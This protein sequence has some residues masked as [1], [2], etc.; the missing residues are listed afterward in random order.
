[1]YCNSHKE[2]LVYLV[3][4]TSLRSN[5]NTHPQC[6]L[7]LALLQLLYTIFCLLW[8]NIRAEKCELCKAKFASFLCVNKDSLLVFASLVTSSSMG[9]FN[10]LGLL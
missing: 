6:R 1:M 2:K 9:L 3:S 5:T 10:Q 8:P 4:V 7:L